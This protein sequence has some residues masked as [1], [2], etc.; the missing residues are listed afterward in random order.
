MHGDPERLV[1]PGL[2]LLLTNRAFDQADH[3]IVLLFGHQRADGF[4]HFILR[5]FVATKVIVPRVGLG[6][7]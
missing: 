2:S 3:F 7:G 5:R 6:A 1:H 4:A